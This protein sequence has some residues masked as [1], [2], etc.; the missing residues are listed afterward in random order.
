MQAV[1]SALFVP[2]T[3]I[4]RIMKAITTG[5]DAVIVDLEDAVATHAKSQAR[6]DLARFLAS[7]PEI[8]L[9]VRINNATSSFFQEDL[10]LCSTYT[11][12]VGI[13][14]PKAEAG[15]QV[16]T[17]ASLGRAVYPI[18]ESAQGI[19]SMSEIAQIKGV[20]RLSFGALDFGVD[21]M[22]DNDSEGA[23]FLLNQ[24]RTQLVLQSRVA[25][26]A[27]PLDGVYPHINDTEGL[28]NAMIFAKG[29]GFAGALC[30]HPSQVQ[31]IHSVMQPS[32][33]EVRW[34]NAV[35]AKYKETG[36][37]AFALEGKMVDM[38]VIEKAQ[39]IL[40]KSF[41]E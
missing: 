28:K 38:P 6:E 21:L 20:A 33:E 19:A 9:W 10:A 15:A 17:V 2:A 4:D 3:R 40:G 34:A 35:F 31:I 39:R 11:N 18:I 37:A 27:A 32:D 26:I 16:A 12:V 1:R 29:M 23:V 24:I 13:M 30:I 8:K 36:E 25:R 7:Y 41:L 14:L 5:A 22:L